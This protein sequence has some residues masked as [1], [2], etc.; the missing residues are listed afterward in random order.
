[1]FKIVFFEK[2]R[3]VAH[4]RVGVLKSWYG[5]VTVRQWRAH[6]SLP[7]IV[8]CPARQ[9]ARPP[10]VLF[11]DQFEDREERRRRQRALMIIVITS[12]VFLPR[13]HRVNRPCVDGVLITAPAARPPPH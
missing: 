9:P 8:Y 11:E 7:C 4:D 13:T 10:Q 5:N 1:M 3:W 12:V 2:G 6:G